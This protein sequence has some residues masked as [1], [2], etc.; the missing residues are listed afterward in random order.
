MFFNSYIDMC[1]RLSLHYQISIKTYQSHFNLFS[2]LAYYLHVQFL[3][4]IFIRTQI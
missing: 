4:V 2:L 3:I 1:V